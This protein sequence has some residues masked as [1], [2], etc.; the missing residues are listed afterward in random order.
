[1][2]L[3]QNILGVVCVSKIMVENG[4]QLSEI[5]NLEL[6]DGLYIVILGF[7]CVLITI[8]LSI[9]IVLHTYLA[10]N[11]M[12]SWEYFSWMKITYLKVWPRKYGSPFTQGSRIK[13]LKAFFKVRR[14]VM[15]Y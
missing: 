2:Q 8:S 14:S 12:T 13:N 1:M 7:V 6:V 11:A 4:V 3:L 15:A 9:L 5:S 10:A